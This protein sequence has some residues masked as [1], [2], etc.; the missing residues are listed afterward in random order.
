LG[1]IIGCGVACQLFRELDASCRIII[2]DTKTHLAEAF[3]TNT[4]R[5]CQRTLRSPYD[6]Q[7][8]PD[9]DLQLVDFARLNLAC[10]TTIER[11]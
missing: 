2:L 3:F 8:A 5:N 1:G 9:E 11:Q 4:E 6:Q 7:L 10:L